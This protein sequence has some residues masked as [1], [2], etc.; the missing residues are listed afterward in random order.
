MSGL[1]ATLS[2]VSFSFLG[3][4]VLGVPPVG[5]SGSLP[6]SFD[7]T[8]STQTWVA[9]SNET[10]EILA[11]GAAGGSDL[12]GGNS[13]TG[14]DMLGGAGG[15]ELAT[16]SVTSGQT[17][18]ITA[19]A[20]GGN[21]VAYFSGGGGYGGGANG[22]GGGDESAPGGGGGG[23]ASTITDNATGATLV[24]GGGGGGAGGTDCS[25]NFIVHCSVSVGTEYPDMGGPGGAGGGTSA[26]AGN[27][28]ALGGG[29]RQPG[30]GGG[31]AVTSGSSG[32]GGTA[33]SSP[34]NCSPGAAGTA[35]HGGN[36]GNS[37]SI[38][39]GGGGGGGGGFYGGG[40][41]GGG[42]TNA[43]ATSPGGGGGGGS[44]YAVSTSTNVGYENGANS[45]DGYVVIGTPGSLQLPFIG[46]A[47][48]A[49]EA[50]GN[51]ATSE[52]S[53]V[54]S[55]PVHDPVNAMDG[56]FFDT[57]TDL[58]VAAP[59]VPLDFTRT[60]D[61][62]GAQTSG[63]ADPSGLGPGW[64]DNLAMSVTSLLGM[65][66]VT[67]ANG[68]Q[69]AFSTYNAS[70]AW[71]SS[72]YN[73]C[74]VAPRDIATLN[75]NT[76]GTWTFTDDLASPLTYTFSSAGALTEIANA[77][78]QSIT[79]S[80]E[81]AGTG[82]CPSSAT[83]CTVWTSNAATPNPTLTLVFT[84]GELTEVV[85]FATSGG[86]APNVA[87]CYYAETACS[88]PSSGG[89]ATSL[90]AATDP[91]SL[92]TTYTYDATNSTSSLDYDLLTRTGPDGATLTNVYNS[93]GQISQQ[94]DPAGSVSTY[95]YTEQPNIPMGDG[96]GDTTTVSVSPGTGLP[97]EVTQ[98][99][100]FSGALASTTLDP[101][102]SSP[103]TSTEVRS[104]ITAQPTNSTDA[105]GNIT[106]T[107]LP[108]PSTPSAYLN[109]VAP[110][111]VTDGAGNVTYEAS[112]ATNLVWCTVEPAEADN[113]VTCPSTEP[114]TAPTPGVKN[115]V[116]LGATITYYDAAGNPTYVTD[117][118][119]NTTETAYTSAEQPFC[120]VDA[121]EFTV[122]GK[123]CPAT[124]P[125]SAP[126]G[127]VTG[128]TTTLYNTAGAPSSVT[129]PD[130]A[131]TT[132]GYTD[133]S[134]PD[135]ATSITDPPGDVTT[136]TL[137]AAGQQVQKTETSA[138]SGFSATTV[139]AYDGAGRLYCTIDPLAYSQGDTACPS[140]APTSPPSAGSDPWPG[141][142]ITIFNGNGQPT[143]E[144]NPLGGVSVTAY[145][146]AGNSYCTITPANYANG[147]T[148]P[149][150]GSSWT[151]GI[152]LNQF[153]AFGRVGETTNALGGTTL[154]TYD[155]VGNVSQSTVES[156][157]STNAPN[158]VTSYHYDA[159]NRVIS[160]T[161]DPGG[162][163]LQ[164]KTEQ[165]YDPDGNTFCSVSANAVATA[166]FQ[167]PT[168][169]TTWI[170][171]PPSPSSLYSTT[172]TSAQANDV[173]IAFYDANG[174]EVQTTNPDVD[175]TVS[176]FDPDGRTYCS[177]DPTNVAA[178]L[179]ANPSGSYPYLCP[180]SPPTSAPSTSSDPGYTTTIYDAAGNT[181]FSSDQVGDTMAYTYDAAGQVLTTTDPGGNVTTNCYFSES[182]SGQCA[183]GAAT[184]GGLSSDL[185]STTTPA[186]SADPT[187]ELTTYTYEPGG[188]TLSTTNPAGTATDGYD[189]AGDLTSS[190][191][192]GVASGYGTPTTVSKTYNSDQ[193]VDTMSDAS[194]T[195]TYGY[196]DAGN[197]TSQSLLAAG[198]LTNT[199]VSYSYYSS[200]A[201]D[202]LTYPS[203][204][205]HSSPAV[206]YA[207]D[208][209]G[210][211]ASS[212]DWLGNQVTFA[213]DADNNTTGQDNNVSSSDPSGTSSTAFSYDAA[214]QMNSSAST[215]AQTCGGSETLTQGFS[216]SAGSRN[217]DGQL[218]AASDNYSGSCSGQSNASEDYSYDVAGRVTY[219]GSS[220][221]GSS[222][223]NIG[224]DA[225][226]DPTT[227]SQDQ[228]GT[229]DTYTGAFDAA[230]EV[231]SQTPIS[232]SGGTTSTYSYD[233][234]GD[235]T[236][237]SGG[238]SDSYGYNA[239]TQ[240]T[241]ATTAA[242]S[243]SYLYD[244]NGL[245]SASTVSG[246]TNQLTW[247]ADTSVP[248][249]LAD[250]TNDYIYGPNDT[251]IE[252]VAT[253]SS[254]PTY[255]TYN[256]GD[257]TWVS[258]NQSGD[259]TAFWAYDAFG[260]LLSG[261]PSSPF[262]Y[263]GQ[264]MNAT[265]GFVNDRARWYQPQTGEFDTRDSAFETTD[266]AYTYAGDDPVNGSDPTG[267]CPPGTSAFLTGETL[268][269]WSFVY[270]TPQIVKGNNSG[271]PYGTENDPDPY[272][273]VGHV[274][275]YFNVN[276]SGRQARL[277]QTLG[278]SL[279]DPGPDINGGLQW[280]CYQSN[281][282][283]CATDP[284]TGGLLGDGYT[285][286]TIGYRNP[287]QTS[288]LEPSGT[289]NGRDYSIHLTWN[290]LAEGIPN[291]SSIDGRF[292]ATPV[293]VGVHC[294]SRS[295]SQCMIS[296]V[297]LHHSGDSVA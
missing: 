249:V 165:A 62:H 135:T 217:A 133:A 30:G 158:V 246:T 243:A 76:S 240:M 219:E 134:Y 45:G 287:Y 138:S 52:C 115:T 20:V 118:L 116:A 198:S 108:S 223:A 88:P 239:A 65:A 2:V 100:F 274:N 102:G 216:G 230:G 129:N 160:T 54:A 203:Y 280:Q 73:Y 55:T 256:S 218:T 207:Y 204:S 150:P 70:N 154:T 57:T 244:G 66:T 161:V 42:G 270:V 162:G 8:G 19:G 153:D 234:L 56:D 104:T 184:S 236:A 71:C 7:Y 191:Y 99:A 156:N 130:G 295:N 175:T 183:A 192:S 211:M 200:G 131:T 48:S 167:C 51:G 268:D 46:G 12:Y 257:D 132:Y 15:A 152:T 32:T 78:G 215:M 225:A 141:A 24:V 17:L 227:L 84:S 121:T 79:A 221:Q 81:T 248:V 173:T 233:T 77:A 212:T 168:W 229:L 201:L 265:T 21:A 72:S 271:Y 43:L 41:G 258:T 222:A 182:A 124:V 273:I 22:G 120:Q 117:P 11:V 98:Y 47:I 146:G 292:N 1:A 163:S 189:A 16:L 68:A 103:A 228:G 27:Q 261:S 220:P 235:Q 291:P 214:D 9:P 231:T 289:G 267:L 59:G 282:S 123:S 206:T 177:A 276:L 155:A 23:G 266:T 140:S 74:P 60:Y 190:A 176:A 64:S 147:V 58:S 195:T 278:T 157:D 111:S 75:Q 180:S 28:G 187:G 113:G 6:T 284:N 226:G 109:A 210:Q 171:A 112:S 193:S 136:V 144:V 283:R 166:S 178:W 224:Y 293:E 90:Y 126:T 250:S 50:Q 188:A 296:S 237:Q 245:E 253:A 49:A 4:V 259:E 38:G 285:S 101:S 53:C 36:G 92:T 251:P 96:P 205:G 149:A 63:G 106:T 242:G 297:S 119:G 294:A 272:D 290:W 82:A 35:G 95:S 179:T 196:D 199:T 125:T 151:A 31:G 85:G 142:Q 288:F 5:A 275:M 25:Y 238:A 86:S 94:T 37:C 3:A 197:V 107:T 61:A 97:S 159:D 264:Y 170:T 208:A 172:P 110:T 145:D 255:L 181:L 87:F 279:S 13:S 29:T 39:G 34:S 69:V 232:G 252:Q 105:D 89:L 241:S 164:S 40:G 26:G 254:T 263:S 10:I 114:T 213:H 186:T 137:N 148:C 122:D 260:N 44:S 93:S 83:T 127:T 185:Y 247:S 128:Y 286:R 80:A 269:G 262:G 14:G 18:D 194:G 169:Q 139:M 33:G 277:V 91:G 143:Y 209:T 281:G 67:E 202:T 174:N